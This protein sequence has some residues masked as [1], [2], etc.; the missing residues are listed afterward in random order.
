MS[1]IGQGEVSARAQEAAFPFPPAAWRCTAL[2]QCLSVQ[3]TAGHSQ[4]IGHTLPT[5]GVT[6]NYAIHYEERCGR[7]L[8]AARDIKAG[9]VVFQDTP[10]AVGADNNPGP[11]CLTCY[12]RL[13]GTRVY[14]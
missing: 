6:M 4:N 7:Q 1:G 9:E 2:C 10:A 3:V 11:I 8:I 13:P 14:T 5:D 12:K